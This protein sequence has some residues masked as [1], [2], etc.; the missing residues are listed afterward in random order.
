MYKLTKLDKFNIKN[1]LS[2]RSNWLDIEELNKAI[3]FV[4]AMENNELAGYINNILHSWENDWGHSKTSIEKDLFDY[5]KELVIK[6]IE[7]P[8]NDLENKIIKSINLDKILNLIYYY[9]YKQFSY[10]W[11]TLIDIKDWYSIKSLDSYLFFK[12]SFLDLYDINMLHISLNDYIADNKA[13]KKI[14][15]KH[16]IWYFNIGNWALSMHNSKYDTRELFDDKDFYKFYENE[17]DILKL[18]LYVHAWWYFIHYLFD[19]LK[20]ELWNWKESKDIIWKE[21]FEEIDKTLLTK[22]SFSGEIEL[23]YKFDD[24]INTDKKFIYFLLN[25]LQDSNNLKLKNVMIIDWKIKFII[26]DLVDIDRKLF[27]NIQEEQKE[28]IRDKKIYSTYINDVLKIWDIVIDWKSTSKPW[29][30]IRLFYKLKK[31]WS[32]SVSY[33]DMIM[34]IIS[35]SN[36]FKKIDTTNFSEWQIREILRKK[37]KQ[38]LDINELKPIL[39]GEFFISEE[40]YLEIQK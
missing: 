9:S 31:K 29:E 36:D 5:C 10:N 22:K 3:I 1:L 19:I 28:E 4:L 18:D 35:N 38:I 27:T 17:G 23:I 26:S 16:K 7:E 33:Q 25:N 21:V 13:L 39:T 32:Y 11:V 34:Y 12:N 37:N 30:L 15:N 24:I 40:S 20:S 2:F 8:E 14:I 6:L